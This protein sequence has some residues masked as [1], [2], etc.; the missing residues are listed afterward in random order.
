[1]VIRASAENHG[2][3]AGSLTAPNPAAQADLLKAAYQQAGIDPGTVTY[4]EAHGTGTKL[5]DPIEINGLKSAFIDL[6]VSHVAE[7]FCGIGSVKS[8]I[9]HTELAAGVA[10][11]IKVLLQMRY[12]TL[13]RSL[14]TESINPYL[15][16]EGS[17]FYIVREN[18][19]WQV[20]REL[21]RRA[22]VSSFGIGG[23]NAHV[24]IEEYQGTRVA[25]AA[26]NWPS[27]MFVLSARNEERLHEYAGSLLRYLEDAPAGLHDIAYTL[28]VGRTP[29]ERRLAFVARSTA[30]ARQ[31]LAAYLAGSEPVTGHPLLQRWVK[32]GPVEWRELYG[33]T[34]PRK[35]SLPTYPFARERCWVGTAAA[36]QDLHLLLP[37][38]E[39]LPFAEPAA[40]PA[41]MTLAIGEPELLPANI[42]GITLPAG[43]DTAA[44]EAILQRHS[45]QHL[46]WI[47]PQ[48][49]H[50]AG[51]SEHQEHGLIQLF[52][53]VKAML[54]LGY[55][56]KALRLTIVTTGARAVRPNDAAMPA[57]AGT[58]GFAVNLS[59]EYP[60]WHVQAVDLQPGHPAQ[61]ILD[62]PETERIAALR[63]G[64]WFRP[65]LLPVA[66]MEQE[67]QRYRQGGVYVVIGGSG[68]LGRVW[69]R[70]MQQHFQARVIWI[71]RRPVEAIQ[72]PAPAYFQA[73]A[74][75]PGALRRALQEI[76]RVHGRM[77]GLVHAAM[78]VFDLSLAEM[79]EARF[80]DVL[81]S[82]V[83]VSAQ[84][85]DAVRDEPLDFV[86]FFSS[87]AAFAEAGGYGG[88][89]SGCVFMDA[90]AHALR[91]DLDCPVKVAN[92]GYWGVGSGER[93][94]VQVKARQQRS[95][96]APID[97]EAG[98][99]ALAKFV[100]GPLPQ[101][102][103][104]RTSKP[105]EINGVHASESLT[106]LSALTRSPS[107]RGV[108]LP[109]SDAE[110]L[111]PRQLEADQTLETATARL[112]AAILDGYGFFRERQF[113]I[114]E[115]KARVLF[116]P[117]YDRWLAACLSLLQER[118]LLA[119]DGTRYTAQHAPAPPHAL[120]NEWN[121]ARA[122]HPANRARWDLVETCVR[123]LPDI[124]AGKRTATDVMFPESSLSLVE[125]LYKGNAVADLF[126]GM[127]GDALLQLLQ[128]RGAV[129][130]R[131]LEV[132]AGTGGTTA[133]LLSRLQGQGIAEYLYTDVS[134]A[135]LLHAGQV[136]APEH[137]Y[138]KTALFD[139]ELPP[140]QQGIETGAY[141]FVIAT[142]VLHATRNIRQ[143]LRHV[144]AV[145]RRG[146]VLLLNEVI[147]RRL[148][149]HVTFGL[150][151]GWWRTEDAAL[152]IPGSPALKP[153]S[154][155]RA[156][157][158]EGFT[159]VVFPAEAAQALGQQVI[160]A[161]SDG[162]VRLSRETLPTVKPLPATVP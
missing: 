130:L 24:V 90:L 74:A 120:W 88:Y 147:D 25:P 93:V 71:G 73:D 138:L 145:L 159:P 4:I 77:D 48:P 51:L 144:K 152:R 69:T 34:L 7:P 81:S 46:L 80:R 153:E 26:A 14:H 140:G 137:P 89:A 86:L 134:K 85:A 55:G 79:Q 5:G 108:R 151:D 96:V 50:G 123:A 117:A 136:F 37:T 49:L 13:V 40:R 58:H 146:G 36:P 44:I 28:Q 113:T 31:Q 2:G 148:W 59:Q 9:G 128:Q 91:R 103:I 42:P 124:L 67:Q 161:A 149:T 111:L 118:G 62:L 158:D 101:L 110:H 129:G 20:G 154:W 33:D 82:R 53:I 16:L 6:G 150:L 35:V 155:R 122:A 12:R 54:A 107:I 41:M 32:G 109:A 70:W 95:G 23:V 102:G 116:K 8:N 22:G 156:L 114:E 141:D 119:S 127:L 66:S 27:P 125:P 97:A 112:L 19:P 64:E 10:G 65:T 1:G 61:Q 52:R 76:R 57:H 78:D 121:M 18:Q 106:L 29:M 99:E 56:D 160:L 75:Q 43:A 104:V 45:F 72:P 105:A 21:P 87:M 39:T 68:G 47:A 11:V 157:A 30:E 94:S 143:T 162:W 131:I 15:R 100:N 135:F 84:I 3:R 133:G 98:M 38:W 132:G 83:N 60:Q 115:L 126:N 139:A 17:P 142:N 63:D 92:W